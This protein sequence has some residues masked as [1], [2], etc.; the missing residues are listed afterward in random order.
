MVKFLLQEGA[1]VNA[2]NDFGERA[3]KFPPI[4][5]SLS[6]IS[7]IRRTPLHLA[8]ALF[9]N[10]NVSRTLLENGGDL[11]NRNAD[12]KTPLHTF[13]SQF[14]EQILRCH[15]F[16]LEFSARDHRG[17]S[18]LHYLAWSSKTSTEIFMRYHERSSLDL[19][20]VDAEGRSM[21][22]L[23]A[24]RGNVSVADCLVYAAKDSNINHGNSRG[25]TVLHYG[26]ES[27][28]ACDTI[29][30]LMQ[31]RGDIW[32]RDC[33]ERSALH[34]AAKLGNLR[35]VEALLALGMADELRAADCFRMNPLK[36]AGYHKAHAV[37]TFLSEIDSCWDGGKE[38]TGPSLVGCKELSA[39][40]IHKSGI[41]PF[42]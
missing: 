14:S 11:H 2:M 27:K 1:R 18:L 33:H 29:T 28:R 19:R 10:Y 5:K 13:P 42:Q 21:L 4:Y 35:A 9:K 26:A 37:L 8:I 41:M 15:K 32:A 40:E 39:A 12:R 34:H 22:H 17:M 24:Q 23:A 3:C 25:R 16:L 6:L 36:I 38:L 7:A 31:H 30:A 20:T